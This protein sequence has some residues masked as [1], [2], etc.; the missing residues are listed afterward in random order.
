MIRTEFD[1]IVVGAGIHGVGIAQA[2][3]AAGQT[4][5]VL[6]QQAIASG[7]S[8]RSSKLIHGGLRYLEQFDLHLV[9]ESLEERARLLKLAPELVKLV[10]FYIP[11]Y[12]STR[13]RP[14]KIRA[15]LSLYALLG[16][17]HGHT[18]FHAVPRREWKDLD[19]LRQEE[20][21]AVFQYWDAQTDDAALT[22][23]VMASAQA[24]GA[25]LLV[26][27]RF[28]SAHI[29]DEA[30]TA[31][32][33][34]NGAQQTCTCRVL[35]N[36]AGPWVNQ[37][38]S[39]IQPPLAPAH[40]DLVQGTHLILDAKHGARIYYVEAPQ[41][42]RAVFIMP[43]HEGHTLVGTTETLFKGADPAAVQPLPAEREYLLTVVRRYFP[44]MPTTV[45]ASFAGLRVLPSAGTR[46]FQRSREIL[47]LT[48][49]ERDPRVLTVYGGKL[50]SYRA[51]AEHALR[52]IASSLPRRAARADTRSLPLTP[53]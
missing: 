43:W 4:V 51:D 8:S 47:L 11:V 53:A 12:R 14:W 41:D 34:I 36:A 10:P 21:Q 42:G 49:R 24:L 26:P 46:A 30:C 9:H 33:S 48:D 19:G 17:L 45:H 31:N 35:V 16:G 32:F 29:Q 18:R 6:E 27:A 37:V 1:V 50:T 22:R 38:A 25:E 13:R 20:L 28:E 2:A 44:A 39:R 40:V 52:L 5:A 23:A 3:A 15:G 7:S